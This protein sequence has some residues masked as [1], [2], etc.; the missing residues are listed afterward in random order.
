MRHFFAL[1]VVGGL[2]ILLSGCSEHERKD[3]S[4]VRIPVD[5]ARTIELS[6][7]DASVIIVKSSSIETVDDIIVFDTTCVIKSGNQLLGFSLQTG[8]SVC[9]YSQP[10]RGP[11]E[12]IRVWDYGVVGD[13]LYLYDIDGKQVL[14]FTVGGDFLHS[15]KVSG[16]ASDY[17]FQ[18][19]VPEPWGDG[20]IGKR[21]FGMPGVPELS[22][23]GADFRYASPRG[24]DELRSGIMLWRQF[25]HG[26]DG[27]ILYNRFFSNEIQR[28][29]A[30]T[31]SVKY[32]VDFGRYNLPDLE[33]DE[34]AYLDLLS[35]D[36]S[37]N[38]YA[39]V[40]SN[41][42]ENEQLFGFQYATGG[43]RCYAL[44]NKVTGECQAYRPVIPSGTV[45]QVF[46]HNGKLFAIGETDN[47]KEMAI[48]SFS[49]R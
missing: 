7:E 43:N 5:I 2:F 45:L 38:R 32:F 18:S 46:N 12:Y 17:P 28:I 23:Y 22:A 9:R 29:T 4:A 3:K 13:K 34:Y 26:A 16:A 37:T 1:L 19:L 40:M 15:V 44:Y 39:V 31:V 20:Y 35:K 25:F 30:D 42:D 48:Y 14:F 36:S 24:I 49:L 21:V 8:K 6:P 10:G 41:F 33:Q 11:G 47:Q 27:D